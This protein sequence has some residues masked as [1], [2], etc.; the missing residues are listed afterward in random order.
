MTLREKRG[1]KLPR[2]FDR[3]IGIPIVFLRGLIR[4][5]RRLPEGIR[6]IGL[7]SLGTIGDG[8]LVSALA[9]DIKRRFPQARV[10][11]VISD[12]NRAITPLLPDVDDFVVL[13]LSRPLSAI[14]ALRSEKFDLLI[15]FLQ[16]PRISALYASL[17]GARFTTG[18]RTPG[19]HRHFAYDQVV[20][21]SRSRHE[22]DNFQ[23][24]VKGLGVEAGGKPRLAVDPDDIAALRA[25]LREPYVVFH[26][27][28]SGFKGFL[29]EWPAE[30]YIE[31]AKALTKDGYRVVVTGGPSDAEKTDALVR[32][33]REAGVEIESMA[34]R[35]GLTKTA[36]LLAGSR[37]VVAVST[38]I[39]HL[40]A[41]LDLPLVA[42]Y[43]PTNPQ[44]WGPLSSK[45]IVV[46]PEGVESGYLHLG[47][48]YPD[49]PVDCMRF[50]SVERVLEAV[51]L[52]LHSSE[53]RSLAHEPSLAGPVECRA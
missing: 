12:A 31:L 26:P 46:A 15:D 39:L 13:T 23:T 47:F 42:L 4:S 17:A 53:E 3:Y 30:R 27:W 14:R 37:L 19:Q 29:R 44:R 25:S 43:G 45:A 24:L 38:G 49:N 6:H 11:M 5:R 8:L 51:R 10:T 28:A 2:V 20:D 16:W 18:F 22:L 9:A 50:I 36:A 1:A 7:I 32:A 21:H 41:A 48:E 40:A 52:A 33:A 34:G 35:L